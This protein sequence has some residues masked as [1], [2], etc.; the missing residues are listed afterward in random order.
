M[1]DGSAAADN[2]VA[3]YELNVMPE[4]CSNIRNGEEPI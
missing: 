4:V 1:N 3:G 2:Y